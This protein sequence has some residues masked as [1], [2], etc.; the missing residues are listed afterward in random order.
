[1]I[2]DNTNRNEEYLKSPVSED[3][4]LNEQGLLNVALSFFGLNRCLYE[5]SEDSSV[6]AGKNY[7]EYSNG[8]YVLVTNPTGSPVEQGYYEE[9]QEKEVI[10][11]KQYLDMAKTYCARC[12]DWSFLIKQKV[13]DEE[14]FT[15]GEEIES[16]KDADSSNYVYKVND[17]LY[18]FVPFK[19]FIFQYKLPDD[20]LKMKYIN[21]ALNTGFAIKGRYFYCNSEK[22]T[23]D[24]ISNEFDWIPVDF[25]YMIAYRV[26]VEMAP[27]VDAN[28]SQ[29]ATSQF[30]IAFQILKANEDYSFR[31]ENPPQDY[32]INPRSPYWNG[33]GILPNR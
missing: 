16:E 14:E 9:S 32:A 25:A 3:G 20:F 6:V 26:A 31:R 24:Y 1:M 18:E 5:L 11:F 30:A 4:Q 17:K 23:I 13:F 29:M 22:P 12:F 10:L 27:F 7:Y 2:K 19:K 15:N 28:A 21:G 8:E 33:K